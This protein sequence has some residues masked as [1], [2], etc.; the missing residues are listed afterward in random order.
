MYGAH[1][2]HSLWRLTRGKGSPK[3]PSWRMSGGSRIWSQ[4]SLTSKPSCYLIHNSC[5]VFLCQ[6]IG[7]AFPRTYPVFLRDSH[8]CEW[9]FNNVKQPVSITKGY[10]WFPVFLCGSFCFFLLAV[11]GFELRASCLLG[12]LFTIDA[13][14]P[15]PL[16]LVCFSHTVL[17]FCLGQL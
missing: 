1:C 7:L 13:M 17:H 12:K 8:V 11:L 16:L 15:V 10:L 9:I 4:G 5:C 6:K 3:T 2:A 14:P